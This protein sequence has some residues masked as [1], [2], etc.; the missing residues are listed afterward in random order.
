MKQKQGPQKSKPIWEAVSSHFPIVLLRTPYSLSGALRWR[1]MCEPLL[2]PIV[3][4][5]VLPVLRLKQMDNVFLHEVLFLKP[6]A[7]DGS[8]VSP[9]AVQSLE[10]FCQI[11]AF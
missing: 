8:L 7:D 3:V 1:V 6:F 4:L 11:A 2:C 9:I 5:H 10:L